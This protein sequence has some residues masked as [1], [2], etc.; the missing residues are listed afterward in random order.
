MKRIPE[1]FRIKTIER[2]TNL[3]LHQPESLLQAQL[4]IMIDDVTGRRGDSS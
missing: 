3:D 4:A 1:P 2:I